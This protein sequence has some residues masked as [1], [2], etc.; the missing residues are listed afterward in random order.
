MIDNRNRWRNFN[1]MRL[2]EKYKRTQ[3]PAAP[4][5]TAPQQ[6]ED[7]SGYNRLGK[8]IGDA[9]RDAVAKRRDGIYEG[10]KMNRL[11]VDPSITDE[12]LAN[13]P[14]GF[15]NGYNAQQGIMQGLAHP[16]TMA[17]TFG[18]GAMNTFADE[19]AKMYGTEAMSVAGKQAMSGIAEG[20]G[21]NIA[22]DV[23]AEALANT[24]AN[25]LGNLSANAITAADA[26]A[27][28]TTTAAEGAGAAGAASSVLGPLAAAYGVYSLGNLLDWW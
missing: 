1:D 5:Q 24:S 28:A 25:A 13:L 7:F 20:V 2:Y 19:V 23:G 9:W 11:G 27:A 26:T 21:G 6:Q 22:A 16:E 3:A 10:Q 15:Q 17:N 18:N 8:G 12:Q 14:S 4:A